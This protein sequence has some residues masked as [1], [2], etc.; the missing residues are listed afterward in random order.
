MSGKLPSL[1]D[2]ELSNLDDEIFYEFHYDD[3]SMEED[4]PMGKIKELMMMI[5]ETASDLC[6]DMDNELDDIIFDKKQEYTD[7]FLAHIMSLCDNEGWSEDDLETILE[8]SLEDIFEE[9][10]FA[11]SNYA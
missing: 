3:N 10:I 11:Q 8:M 9:T 7:H 2:Y 6:V 1:D 4:I 5:E